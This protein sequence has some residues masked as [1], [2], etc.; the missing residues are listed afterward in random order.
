[1]PR[2]NLHQNSDP[3]AAFIDPRGRNREEMRTLLDRVI[4]LLL[5]Y[6]STAE[7]RAPSPEIGEFP[8]FAVIS[9]GSLST[10][11][12]LARAQFVMRQSRNLPHP[13]YIGNMESMP[14][15]MALVGAMVMAASKNN[16]LAEEMSPSLT[17]VEPEV[18]K[19]FADRF[20][21]GPKSGGGMLS[22][23]TLANLQALTTA[24]NAKL[25]T[26]QHSVWLRPKPPVILASEA[27]HSS[28]QKAAMVMG[29][30]TSAVIPVRV[31][32]NSRMDPEDLRRKIQHAQDSRQEPFCI[33]ATAGTTITG[34]ID[35]LADIAEIA[36]QYGLWLHTDAI[37]GGA[38]AFSDTYRKRLRGI[39]ASDSLS[40][41][42]HKWGYL[43]TTCSMVLFKDFGIVD[44]YFRIPAPYMND[45]RRATN[46]GEFS[47]QGSRQADII[48]LLLSMQHLGRMGYARLIDGRMELAQHL[49]TGLE[50]IRLLEF[51]GEMDT[52][53]TCFHPKAEST[54]NQQI[55]VLTIELQKHL[56]RDAAVCLTL[57]FY[58]GKRW[59]KADVLNPFTDMLTIE[60]LVDSI[61]SFLRSHPTLAAK[62]VS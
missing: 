46:L 23:G 34:N 25:G 26:K 53:I 35:P 22:C 20:D 6:F 55:E 7:T 59:L 57:P 43:A 18:M 17:S 37:Y 61:H 58:R 5:D 21:L 13:G 38:L 62:A 14:T 16:M 19:W 48:G 51:S 56:L 30:G 36:K 1:M 42:L 3:A 45:V 32:E 49:R 10:D 31:D 47:L 50:Q 52:N 54:P 27:A 9:D 8:D 4:N 2:T 28:L 60:R 24:R 12:L 40:F 11:D 29:L 44:E 41:N 15:T 33:I 39:H